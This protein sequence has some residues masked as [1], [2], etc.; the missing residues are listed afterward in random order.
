MAESEPHDNAMYKWLTFGRPAVDVFIKGSEL[1]KAELLAIRE[2]LNSDPVLA[3]VLRAGETNRID[4]ETANV[5]R[6]LAWL[7]GRKDEQPG[8]WHLHLH[9]VSHLTVRYLKAA[10]KLYVDDVRQRR[11]ALASKLGLGGLATEDLDVAIARV[12]EVLTS[13]PLQSATPL[14]LA[15]LRSRTSDIAPEKPLEAPPHR[16]RVTEVASTIEVLDPDLRKRCVSLLHHLTETQ[17]PEQYDSVLRESTT[18]LEDRLR[19]A[20]G[21]PNELVGQDLVAAAFK[22]PPKLKLGDTKSEKEAAKL[23]FMGAFGFLRNPPHH[24]LFANL[25]RERVVQLLG[26]VDYLL[27]LIDDGTREVKPPDADV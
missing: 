3:E 21:L 16:E 17:A 14:P 10:A 20:C 7:R 18:I 6:M 23:L 26:L 4:E 22:Q 2:G 24:R 1:Y 13:P 5:E 12:E 11:D 25:R 9:N 8:R 27:L 15:F 19:S